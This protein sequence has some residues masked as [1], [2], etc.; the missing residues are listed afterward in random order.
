MT[1]TNPI[2]WMSLPEGSLNRWVLRN[3]A[4]GVQRFD[5]DQL[6]TAYL[7]AIDCVEADLE[8]RTLTLTDKGREALEWCEATQ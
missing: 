1:V 8:A 6:D 3:I 5:A 4:D 2:Y 7:I